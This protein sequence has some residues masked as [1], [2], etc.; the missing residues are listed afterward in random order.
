MN[1]KALHYLILLAL[2]PVVAHAEYPDMSQEQMQK[3]MAQAQKM[4]A[5][6]SQADPAA[7]QR[8]AE[9]GKALQAEISAMCKSGD[10]DGAQKRAVAY[11]KEMMNDKAFQV[12]K[13]CGEEIAQ[14]MPQ[15]DLKDYSD[16][17]QGH[18]C[19]NYNN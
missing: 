6:F 18:V 14:T 9:Q 17:K 2:T 10:R 13:K 19:D 16:E 3:M 15:M 11:A 8:M 4:Q 1:K 12:M 5:C 7:M